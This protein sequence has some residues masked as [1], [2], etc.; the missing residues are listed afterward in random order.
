MSQSPVTTKN[1]EQVVFRRIHGR[2]VPIKKKSGSQ[3]R[4]PKQKPR[5]KER[6]A[7]ASGGA[8][9][10]AAGMVAGLFGGSAFAEFGKE[11]ERARQTSKKFVEKAKYIDSQA[12]WLQQKIAQRGK[13][14]G[15]GSFV[16]SE[17]TGIGTDDVQVLKNQSALF[18]KSAAR[19]RLRSM[20]LSKQGFKVGG[21]AIGLGG[22]L[23]AAGGRRLYQGITGREETTLP[24]EAFTDIGATFVLGAAS[25][26]YGLKRGVARAQAAKILKKVLSKGRL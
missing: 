24:E 6:I 25:H 2:V 26:E 20:R 4:Q 11:S 12:T 22:F 18:R 21:S 5:I 1:G 23:V 19:Q 16:F 14:G 17:R 10:F 9:T 13:Q 8:A 15:G 7:E 3:M